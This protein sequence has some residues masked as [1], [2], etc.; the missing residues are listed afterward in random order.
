MPPKS[1]DPAK[2]NASRSTST[3]RDPRWWYE[4]PE[5][6]NLC[7]TLV[8]YVAELKQQ[9]AL[10]LASDLEN[11]RLYGAP[12]TGPYMAS[13]G[14]MAQ[15]QIGGGIANRRVTISLA[16]ACIDTLRSK[17]STDEPRPMFI[18]TGGD[19][20]AQQLAQQLQAFTDGAF[21][22]THAYETAL[23]AFVDAAIYGTGFLFPYVDDG[24]RLAIE[25]VSPF[26]IFV[27]EADALYGEPRNLY[28]FKYVDRDHLAGLYP[29]FKEQIASAQG[30]KSE[31]GGLSANSRSNLV[32]VVEAWHLPSVEDAGDGKHVIAV[33]NATL[34]NEK[35]EDNE[36][37]LIKLVYNPR[38]LGYF[39]QGLCEPLAPLQNEVN[40][41]L[42]KIQICMHFL[43][44]PHWL[45]PT[46]SNIAFG[47]FNNQIGS[48]INYTGLPPEL[49]VWA[50]VPRE[51]F[52]HVNWLYAKAFEIAG[53]SQMEAQSS[54]PGY[55]TMSGAAVREVRDTAADRFKSLE[56]AWG[57][58]HIDLA[59][60]LVK[61]AATIAGEAGEYK[62][63]VVRKSLTGKAERLEVI[64]WK[65]LQLKERKYQIQIQPVSKFASDIPGALQT[66]QELVQ[67]GLMDPDTFKDLM[68]FPDLKRAE[69][70]EGASRKLAHKMVANILDNSKYQAPDPYMNLEYAVKYGT[71]CLNLA[72]ADGMPEDRVEDLRTWVSA[73]DD[74]MQSAATAQA[75]AVPAPTAAPGGPGGGGMPPPG[76]PMQPSASM[77]PMSA[78]MAGGGMPQ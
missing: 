2:R 30:L 19:Y 58:F 28:R 73:C 32:Q 40:S 6:E 11:L 67:A 38:Q 61:M 3:R 74:L 48:V 68:N 66:G 44:V 1:R 12:S 76:G 43:A 60:R 8:S 5:D 54:V 42:W 10:R 69:D 50:S 17:L 64:D 51:C 52:E 20:T 71:L 65:Q 35:Y 72:I 33:S 49:K 36:H 62:V 56:K 14:G 27:D 13:K 77:D 25:R 18:T 21:Y 47:A 4:V 15:T 45:K 22:E 37:A 39:G 41:L 34:L 16:Q 53:V 59:Q 7:G 75:S 46:A 9:N 70:I 55:G 26:E 78:A 57:R 63:T 29:K 31:D 23:Q 24:D